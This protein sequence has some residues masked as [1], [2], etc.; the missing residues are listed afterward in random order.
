MREKRKLIQKRLPLT[1]AHASS[2][3]PQNEVED[4]PIHVEKFSLKT[5]KG[6]LKLF[7]HVVIDGDPKSNSTCLN[8]NNPR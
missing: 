3:A 4:S 8:V 7:R 2:G 1:W 6:L 5:K